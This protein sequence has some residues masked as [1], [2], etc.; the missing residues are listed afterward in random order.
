[1]LNFVCLQ[2]IENT[3]NPKFLLK[4]IIHYLIYA[5]IRID[6]TV[7]NLL[8]S[9]EKKLFCNVDKKYFILFFINHINF[10]RR[11]FKSFKF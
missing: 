7:Y 8:I 3:L 9:I 6:K 11:C 4:S 2:V 10:K 1:M 5:R